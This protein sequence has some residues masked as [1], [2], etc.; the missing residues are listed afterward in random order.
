[1]ASPNLHNDVI[2][3]MLDKIATCNRVDACA[4][5]PTNLTEATSTYTKGNYT[6]TA[7]DGNGDWVIADGDTSG[8][9]ISITGQSGNNGTGTGTA[10]YLA[11]SDG[12]TLLAVVDG[13]GDT[14]NSGSAWTITAGK[15]FEVA[16][17]A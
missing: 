6:L 11:F 17:P 15:V 2:D 12:T 9:K 10:T 13:D 5:E 14:I 3:A 4:T 7:G 1:M 16:D 8:R